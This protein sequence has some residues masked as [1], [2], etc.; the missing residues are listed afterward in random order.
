MHDPIPVRP[1]QRVR[2]LDADRS[3]C[4]SGSGPF[5]RRSSESLAFEVF[6][7]EVL[8]AVLIADV[9]ERADVRVGELRDRL[10]LALESL[11]H[12]RG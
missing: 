7:D 6:H 2:D 12:F 3:V 10:R 9:V 8:D 4:S 5:T 11:S 1:V